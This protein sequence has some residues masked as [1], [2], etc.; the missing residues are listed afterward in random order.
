MRRKWLGVTLSALTV[1]GPAV[2]F[3]RA[4]ET[5]LDLADL[6]KASLPQLAGVKMTADKPYPPFE[7]VTKGLKSTPGFITLWH[8]PPEKADADD[9][10]LLGQIPS[11]LLG[12]QFMLS[13]SV[14]GGGEFT[15]FPLDQRVVRWEVQGRQLLLVEPETHYV[16]DGSKDVADA[17]RRTYPER[18]RAAIPILTKA[19][20]G[21][22]IIDLGALLKSPFADIGWLTNPYSMFGGGGGI[23]PQL[24]KFSKRKSFELNTEITA[25][26]AI[27][28]SNPPGSYRKVM[29]HYSFW[30]L[31]RTDYQP[32]VADDRV[33]YFLTA[34]QDWAKPVTERDLFN[35]D[36]DRWHL[37]KRDPQLALSEPKTPIIFYIEKTVPVR[38]RRAVRDGILEWNKA[39]LKI[40]FVNAIEVRQQTDDNEYKDLDPEDMRYSFFRWIVTG[41]G[42]AMGPHR[43]NPYTGQIYDADIVMDDSM[44][45]F[46]QQ[47]YANHLIPNALA[48]QKFASPQ[49]RQFLAAFPM[50]Q[51]YDRPWEQVTLGADPMQQAVREAAAQRLAARGHCNCNYSEMMK[52]QLG[53]GYAMLAPAGPES[54]D[55]EQVDSFLYDTIKEVVMHEVGHT[56]GLRHNFKASSVYTL[57]EI[58]QRRAKGEPTTASVM[59][60]NPVLFFP[61]NATI[62]HYLTPTLGPYDY[63]AIEYG[64]RPYEPGK[65]IAGA[66]DKPAAKKDDLPTLPAPDD[67]TVN[68]TINAGAA[69]ALE[70]IPPDVR[71]KLPPDVIKLLEQSAGSAAPA[72]AAGGSDAPKI[73]TPPAG[74][75][76][77]LQQIASRAAEPELAYSSDED[78]DTGPDPRVARFDCGADPIDWARMRLELID[79]RLENIRDWAVKDQESWYHL[80]SAFV[81]LMYE[82]VIAIDYVGRYI[83]GQYFSRYHKGDANAT[84]PFV[85]VDPKRQR[86]AL[87]FMAKTVFSDS[88]FNVSPD[89]LNHLA[90]PRWWHDG[91]VMSFAADF[92][93]RDYISMF[94]WYT[95]VDRLSPST[96]RRMYD[97]ELKTDASD[98]FTVAEFL[99]RMQ[100]SCWGDALDKSR[101]RGGG[102]SHTKPFVSDVRR[103]LQREYLGLIEPLVRY[104]PGVMLSPDLQ[105]MIRYSMQEL[106]RQIGDTL[107]E[108]G[109]DLDFA[110]RAHLTS[111]KQRIDRMLSPE[112]REMEAS[113]FAMFLMGRPAGNEANP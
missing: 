97:A 8:Y 89:L 34:N 57:A 14:A 86:E 27:S 47:D 39:F 67:T 5:E 17:V 61:K 48:A 83:G 64:Y 111:C 102:W 37:Q 4:D 75:A 98:K 82:R 84:P 79:K 78:A 24:S 30:A 46:F 3:A 21:D 71:A 74:E 32:R 94:Q 35:R 25:D 29:V 104:R 13:T 54:I 106:A 101:L 109:A 31:P 7:E 62:G 38:F 59:D 52:H 76:E 107:Q 93:I 26:L 11:R 41:G 58:E 108:G 51:R 77:M 87:D 20:S 18:I 85:L 92:P 68:I 1:L 88:F 55:P 66:T 56:L 42:F 105:A 110:S 43:A 23:N 16:T 65:P 36:I 6:V 63:W 60:Y 113:P 2:A 90:P 80:R 100:S 95:L 50:Y 70:S 112:L 44:V 33:G 99:E 73:P 69:N 19:P 10:K 53:L 72:A 91:M 81:R 12:E 49:A 15:A 22:P 96:L 9:D 28:Q 40:G 103:S 45:R